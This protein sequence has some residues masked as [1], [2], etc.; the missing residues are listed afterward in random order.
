MNRHPSVLRRNG[1]LLAAI[2]LLGGCLGLAPAHGASV[3]IFFQPDAY[4]V[5]EDQAGLRVS[6]A[7]ETPPCAGA[8]EVLESTATISTL[9]DGSATLGADFNPV[10]EQVPLGGSRLNF[11]RLLPGLVIDDLALEGEEIFHLT[12]TVTPGA[13]VRC[14]ADGVEYSLTFAPGDDRALVTILDDDTQPLLRL[15]MPRPVKEG[16]AGMTEALVRVRLSRPSFNAVIVNFAAGGCPASGSADPDR[17]YVP[18]RRRLTFFFPETEKQVAVPIVGDL[19]DEGDET[20]PI[21]LS[22]PDGAGI[23]PGEGETSGTILDDDGEE[24]GP[25]QLVKVDGDGQEGAPGARLP[26]PLA[27]KVVRG[28]GG[29][30]VQDVEVEWRAIPADTVLTLSAPATGTD[31]GSKANVTLGPNAGPVT[32]TASLPEGGGSVTFNLRGVDPDDPIA[33]D[34]LCDHPELLPAAARAKCAQNRPRDV[35]PDEV[36]TQADL[37][38]E[39]VG[40]QGRFVRGRLEAWDGGGSRGPIGAASAKAGQTGV[41][42]GVTGSSGSRTESPLEAGYDYSL[43]GLAAGVDGEPSPGRLVGGSVGFLHGD[44]EFADAGGSLGLRLFTLTAYGAYESLS[45]VFHLEGFATWGWPRYCLA[46][47]VTIDGAEPRRAVS[48][49]AGSLW[50]LSLGGRAERPFGP[51]TLEARGF[52]RWD[53]AAIGAFTESGAGDLDLAVAPQRQRSLVAEAGLRLRY[54]RAF[55]GW[56]LALQLGADALHQLA[57]DSRTIEWRFVRGPFPQQTFSVATARPDRDYLAFEAELHAKLPGPWSTF[58][59]ARKEAQHEDLES[60]SLVFG[61]LAQF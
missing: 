46:R 12:L 39:A 13:A 5:P 23:A 17:D 60:R 31:G 34:Q 25:L 9:A 24:V 47:A 15:E 37:G 28:D 48:S 49:A 58:L 4:A 14:E 41:Y 35:L 10:S 1:P 33:G 54:S 19:D 30:G 56:A 45:K 6:F 22:A 55:Q 3:R 50:E 27:V 61:V 20:F 21:C 29:A 59:R 57:D 43:R 8:V 26:K 42:A 16:D 52:A 53:E 51:F 38:V 7:I 44:A 32:V 40:L 18:V 11:S 36:A 2:A